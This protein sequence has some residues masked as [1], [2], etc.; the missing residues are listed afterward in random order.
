MINHFRTLLANLPPLNTTNIPVG[1][2]FISSGFAP[3]TIPPKLA[4]LYS[5]F[6]P[7]QS[8]RAT[9]NRL[10]DGYMQQMHTPE[11]EKFV[12]A[13]DPRITYDLSSE[14]FLREQARGRTFVNSAFQGMFT[15]VSRAVITAEQSRSLFKQ[16]YPYEDHIAELRSGYNGSQ[17]QVD[18]ITAALAALV[19]QLEKE[20]IRRGGTE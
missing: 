18:K 15:K 5:T 16:F 11:M 19:Y 8:S 20:R 6:I 9:V 4:D 12:T 14:Y 3:L 1:E 10:V 13:L 17:S 2:A 7:V